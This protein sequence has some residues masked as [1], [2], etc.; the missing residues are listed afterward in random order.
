MFHFFFCDAQYFVEWIMYMNHVLLCFQKESIRCK[1]SYMS[2]NQYL[3]IVLH[4]IVLKIVLQ[5]VDLYLLF[6]YS[7]LE[8]RKCIADKKNIS[9]SIFA[10]FVFKFSLYFSRSFSIS[11]TFFFKPDYSFCLFFIVY[12]IFGV[13]FATSFL[14]LF[15]K[16]LSIEISRYFTT[17]FLH[18]F[19]TPYFI[20]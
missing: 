6:L 13:C 7:I 1:G 16:F 10:V 3:H 14:W 9:S 20:L 15:R 17:T 18:I 12:L 5:M 8:I 19:S 11:Q 4:I 2:T